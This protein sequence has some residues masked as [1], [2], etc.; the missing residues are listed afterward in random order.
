M[1]RYIYNYCQS[2]EHDYVPF[3]IHPTGVIQFVD[4]ELFL[5]NFLKELLMASLLIVQKCFLLSH[6][7]SLKSYL[8]NQYK[9]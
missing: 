2:I 9:F 5:K 3:A 6:N 8:T 7:V 1:V 4:L